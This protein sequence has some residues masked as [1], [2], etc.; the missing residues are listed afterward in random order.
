MIAHALNNPRFDIFHVGIRA[1]CRAGAA[2]APP[3]KAPPVNEAFEKYLRV[4]YEKLRDRA[5]ATEQLNAIGPDADRL[6]DLAIAYCVPAGDEALLGDI[7]ILRRIVRR[8]QCAQGRPGRAAE[9]A[10]LQEPQPR[11]GGCVGGQP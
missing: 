4:E 7:N 1:V 9:D 6:F 10:A 5:A 3:T 11:S 8:A 2:K